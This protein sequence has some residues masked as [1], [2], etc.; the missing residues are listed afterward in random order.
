MVLAPLLLVFW[1]YKTSLAPQVFVVR[2]AFQR[3]KLWN[4]EFHLGVFGEME[5]ESG[6]PIDLSWFILFIS[7]C[8]YTHVYIYIHKCVRVKEEKV[9]MSTSA[10][11]I[12]ML[13]W[14]NHQLVGPWSLQ[15]RNNF[16]NCFRIFHACSIWY[17][18]DWRL[19]CSFWKFVDSTR[20]FL[21]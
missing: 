21:V 13:E 4:V 16:G 14:D 15:G 7:F 2:W 3:F 5:A 11:L 1:E 20:Y 9:S 10:R 6:E 12:Q 19:N 17:S 8:Q 18:T